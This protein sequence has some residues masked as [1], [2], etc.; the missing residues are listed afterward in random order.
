MC[1]FIFLSSF[2]LTVL[3]DDEVLQESS[4]LTFYGFEWGIKTPGQ[5]LGAEPE[6][7]G[8]LLDL[9]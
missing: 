7:Y 9:M 1:S 5:L 3:W 4:G 6:G 2:A 8:L